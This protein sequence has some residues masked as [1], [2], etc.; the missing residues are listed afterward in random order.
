MIFALLREDFQKLFFVS[1]FIALQERP[2]LQECSSR[3]NAFII[4]L[5]LQCK[6]MGVEVFFLLSTSA[7]NKHLL[8]T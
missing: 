2:I 8:V 3:R 1:I 4:R 6:G 7:G 5:I